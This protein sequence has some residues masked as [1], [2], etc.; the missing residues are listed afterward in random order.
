MIK[1]EKRTKEYPVF[2]ASDG[3]EFTDRAM[4][5][6]YEDKI[7]EPIFDRANQIPHIIWT[8]QNIESQAD[9]YDAVLALYPRN[10]EDIEAFDAV[11]TSIGGYA[12]W[13]SH[14]EMHQYVR[15]ILLFSC[16]EEHWWGENHLRNLDFDWVNYIGSPDDMKNEYISAID[17]M[18]ENLLE[19]VFADCPPADKEALSEAHSAVLSPVV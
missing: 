5:E 14:E 9:E 15:K 1:V 19:K 10:D 18:V 3:K 13:K 16:R 6:D 2:I 17:T 12:P 7:Q 8:F 4:C 11:I